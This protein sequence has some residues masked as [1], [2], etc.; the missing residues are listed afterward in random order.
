MKFLLIMQLTFSY[1]SYNNDG[2][3][4]IHIAKGHHELSFLLWKL[5]IASYLEALSMQ[6]GNTVS[7]PYLFIFYTVYFDQLPPLFL[8]SPA[9]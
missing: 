4:D 8:D 7:L 6:K 9:S 5:S 1:V 2:L 3:S